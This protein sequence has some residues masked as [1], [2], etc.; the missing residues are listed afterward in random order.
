MIV[1]GTSD[2]R[3]DIDVPNGLE[4]RKEVCKDPN[5]FVCGEF[6]QDRMIGYQFCPHNCAGLICAIGIDVY[7]GACREMHYRCP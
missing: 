5:P 7:G 2:S 3:V 6:N 1:L 4:A